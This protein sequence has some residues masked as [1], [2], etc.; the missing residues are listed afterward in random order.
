M[1]KI[2]KKIQVNIPFRMLIESYLDLFIRHRLNPEIGLDALAL[3]R[4]ALSDFRNIATQFM[5]AG[6]TVTLHG[7]FMDLSPGSQDPAVRKLTRYRFEQMLELVPLFQP[8]SVVCH[9]G[10]DKLRY[11]YGRNDWIETS[12][13]MWSWLGSRL[14]DEGS[15]LMLENVYEEGPG[16]IR[17]LFDNLQGEEVGFCLDTGHQAAFGQRP[18]ADWIKS[19]GPFL[20]QIHLHDNSGKADEHL[21]PGR[22]TIDFR[23]LFDFLK[24]CPK[25]QP[26][27]ITLEPHTEEDLW[28]SLEYLEKVWDW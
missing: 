18:L 16:D 28:P 23:P 26:P 10:Y 7:P 19:L 20:R 17:I 2:I 4:Y 3:E 27:I 6:L 11:A 15:A 24:T 21:A 22:G 1:Q 13:E 8:K 14:K 12:L 5:E 25:E 9:A